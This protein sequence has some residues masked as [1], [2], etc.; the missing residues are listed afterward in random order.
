M[1]KIRAGQLWCNNKTNHVIKVT[2]VS[3]ED[4]LQVDDYAN[5][6]N[7]RLNIRNLLN[8]YTPIKPC[9]CDDLQAT[10]DMMQQKLDTLA[11]GKNRPHEYDL[12]FERNTNALYFIYDNKDEQELIGFVRD[13]LKTDYGHV[14]TV[15]YPVNFKLGDKDLKIICEGGEVYYLKLKEVKND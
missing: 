12:Y 11:S 5:F 2:Y 13:L 8:E 3:V 7:K 4:Y 6:S 10:I 9:K 14:S 15:Y 1:D